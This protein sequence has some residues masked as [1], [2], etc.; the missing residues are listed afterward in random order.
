VGNYFEWTGSTSTM[1]KYYYLP[2]P[3]CCQAGGQARVAMRVGSNAPYYILTDHGYPADSLAPPPSPSTAPARLRWASCATTPTA[4]ARHSAP[5][6]YT[7]GTTPTSRR[8]TGQIE[9]AAIGLYFYNARYYDPALGRFAQADTIVPSPGNPQSLNRYSYVLNSPLVYVDPTGHFE[10]DA[11]K[12]YLRQKYGDGWLEIWETWTADEDWMNMLHAAEG[13]DVLAYLS[14]GDPVYFRFAG[15]GQVLLEDTLLTNDIVG[16]EDLGIFYLWQIHG[17]SQDF[18][19]AGVF[20]LENNHLR[21]RYADPRVAVGVHTL[22][23]WDTVGLQSLW[24]L[25]I[26]EPL[27]LLFGPIGGALGG[28]YASA[29]ITDR[30]G[31]DEGDDD[32]HVTA[33]NVDG[34][35]LYQ[36]D[37]HTVV[38]EGQVQY[39]YFSY[40]VFDKSPYLINY[41][42]GTCP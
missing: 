34:N 37:S 19:R 31:G 36:Y 20:Y 3:A 26:G 39:Q 18:H 30:W 8:F 29:Y 2:A 25:L 1:K 13:G 16:S 40:S 4:Q 23:K 11:I 6:R 15:E 42:G 24:S 7:S 21:L 14:A 41:C 5:A 17:L 9:D 12:D 22:T 38:R 35:I 10:D 28:G 27:N 32:V 33:L